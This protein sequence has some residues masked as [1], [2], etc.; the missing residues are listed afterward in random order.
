MVNDDKD[1][2]D[3]EDEG[4]AS[5]TRRI[6][7]QGTGVAGLLG[8]TGTQQVSKD[9][10][11]VTQNSSDTEDESKNP[12]SFAD[13]LL[14][15]GKIVTMDEKG[16]NTNPGTVAEAM[17]VRDGKVVA[18]DSD[19]S[20]LNK[21]K[22]PETQVIN[23]DGKTVIPGIVD[24]HYHIHQAGWRA[25]S[26]D[27]PGLHTVGADLIQQGISEIAPEDF[28][29]RVRSIVEEDVG[30]LEAEK[31]IVPRSARILRPGG[32]QAIQEE[33]LTKD[34][35]D[36]LAPDNPVLVEARPEL[37]VNQRA[38]E[39]FE[40]FYGP[41]IEAGKVEFDS[42]TGRL[43]SGS[44][45]VTRRTAIGHGIFQDRQALTSLLERTQE[46]V[47][48]KG[49]T[50]ISS[51]M[52]QPPLLDGYAIL[53]R[54]GDLDIRVAYS[55]ANAL[56]PLSSHVFNRYPAIQGIGS[57]YLFSAG[58][59]PGFS[60][61]NC[62]I[63]EAPQ[64]VKEG[65]RC[66]SPGSE[67]Y[68]TL[69]ALSKRGHR[70][71]GQHIQGD[72]Q[73]DLF[74]QAVVEGAEEAGPEM[75]VDRI[76][77]KHHSID[78]GGTWPRPDQIPKIKE[79]NIAINLAIKRAWTSYED[80]RDDYSEE[81][82]EKFHQWTAAAKTAVEGG[83]KPGWHGPDVAIQSA[84][85]NLAGMVTRR[86]NEAATES[87][88]DEQYQRTK[89]KE[90]VDWVEIGPDQAVDRVIAMKMATIWNAENMLKEEMIGSLEVGKAADF[91]VLDR[92][93]FTVREEELYDVSAQMTVVGGDIKHQELC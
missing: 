39:W 26:E 41:T 78:H 71:H 63:L 80:V 65:E 7:M 83:V 32:A 62:T 21:W 52:R 68:E 42:N 19:G 27:V 93:W 82:L 86:W 49:F 74:I 84:F 72:K 57:D 92:D 4:S 28:A 76:P 15:N 59:E 56:D 67:D 34:D 46:A 33:L 40:E 51:H 61:G 36:E 22:G 5:S 70:V 69:K 44:A 73:L 16:I 45:V 77:E 54:Q 89:E 30:S 66:S 75:S 35:L 88:T 37:L 2:L 60:D 10:G 38:I 64:E 14:L 48:P 25:F 23:L 29:D 8:L 55:F 1:Q 3:K 13:L 90:G 18:L 31:W 11:N 87:L 91:V 9:E 47:L 85:F 79:H 20:S 24:N 53:D 50:T 12:R 6:F 43:T 81:A 58:V 17:A